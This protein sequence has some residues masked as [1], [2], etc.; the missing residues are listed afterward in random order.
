M[1]S[2]PL[3]IL[4]LGSGLLL[5]NLGVAPVTNLP[6]ATTLAVSFLIVQPVRTW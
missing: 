6:G 1:S 2:P 3:G 5:V 4:G